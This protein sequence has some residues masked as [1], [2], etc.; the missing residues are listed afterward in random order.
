MIVSDVCSWFVSVAVSDVNSPRGVVKGVSCHEKMSLHHWTWS[1]FSHVSILYKWWKGLNLVGGLEHFLFSHM[2]GFSSSQLTKSYFS[3]GWPN[4]QPEINC[5]IFAQ[6][7]R[8]DIRH[9]KTKVR[10][11]KSCHFLSWKFSHLCW[12]D[13]FFFPYLGWSDKKI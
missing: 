8:L 5:K 12:F 7:S 1:V 3:E 13:R 2:L 6:Y 9:V 11:L 10:R 4:H